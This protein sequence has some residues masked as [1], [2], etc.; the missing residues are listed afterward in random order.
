MEL[1]QVG[2]QT[3]ASISLSRIMNLC[4]VYFIK[5]IKNETQMI[6]ENDFEMFY[7]V[8]MTIFRSE[9]S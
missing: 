3:L 5:I 8:A 7:I 4:P 6:L 1:T 9:I 2:V